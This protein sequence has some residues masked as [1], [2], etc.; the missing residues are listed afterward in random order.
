MVSSGWKLLNIL[1]GTELLS[2]QNINSA[3]VENPWSRV[4]LNG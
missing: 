2:S 3:E 4:T 1:Q